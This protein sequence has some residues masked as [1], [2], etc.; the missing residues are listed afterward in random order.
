MK[1]I[2]LL[3]LVLTITIIF[4]SITFAD[5]ERVKAFPYKGPIKNEIV[6][7]DFVCY[8]GGCYVVHSKLNKVLCKEDAK[9]LAKEIAK[10]CRDIKSKIEDRLCIKNLNEKQNIG[11]SKETGIYITLEPKNV[12]KLLNTEATGYTKRCCGKVFPDIHIAALR[13]MDIDDIY[14]IKTVP[15]EMTHVYQNKYTPIAGSFEPTY[16]SWITEGIADYVGYSVIMNNRDDLQYVFCFEKEGG[17]VT[18]HYTDGY[19]CA[20]AFL[21]WIQD[22][23]PK[24]NICD[25]HKY[26]SSG[27][28]P[29]YLQNWFEKRTGRDIR[30][31]WNE[32]AMNGA[33]KR[34][35]N[36][37]YP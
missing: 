17:S 8:G 30:G 6:C 5:S 23:Y 14:K 12:L 25:L 7:N 37:G 26:L 21:M 9:I 32:F 3:L 20:A 24:A 10:Q 18:E 15:H 2:N 13:L 4:S 27:Q 33:Y 19:R 36:L 16:P 31:L 22:T 28:E 1:A 29:R 11:N 35:D 34:F